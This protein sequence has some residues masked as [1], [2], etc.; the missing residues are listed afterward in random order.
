MNTP[1]RIPTK[2]AGPNLI[3]F[4]PPFLKY[5]ICESIKGSRNLKSIYRFF[6]LFIDQV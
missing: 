4:Y 6:D 3:F 1:A 5:D 2:I